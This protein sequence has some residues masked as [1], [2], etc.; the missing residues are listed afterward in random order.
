MANWTNT[1]SRNSAEIEDFVNSLEPH[2]DGIQGS[3]SFGRDFHVWVRVGDNSG[4]KY[5]L[6]YTSGW[7]T[8]TAQQIETMLE[9]GRVKI[10]SFN[11]ENPPRIWYFEQTQ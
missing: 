2:L 9:T 11:M 4:K 8:G 7:G 10:M 1:W 6:K 5:E 3:L